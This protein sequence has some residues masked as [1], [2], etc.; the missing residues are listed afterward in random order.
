MR[1][2]R[3]GFLRLGVEVSAGVGLLSR[4]DLPE[5]Q[6]KERQPQIRLTTK[7]DRQEISLDGSW[8]FQPADA[9]QGVNP[10]ELTELNLNDQQWHHINVPDFW[11]PIDWWLYSPAGGASSEFVAE[12]QKRVAKYT[13]DIWKTLAGWY[14]HWIEIPGGLEGKRFVLRFTGVASVAEVWWNGHKV[15][16]H[17]GMFGPFE[18]DVTSYV[19]PG[20]RNLLSVFVAAQKFDLQ[21]ASEQVDLAVTVEVTRDM[22]SNLAHGG[23]DMEWVDR[24]GGIW[25]PV[26]LRLK[27]S[28]PS[29]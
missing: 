10:T 1:I 20:A 5:G 28:S 18:C 12:E 11:R 8:L 3:R 4:F 27:T 25:A 21:A 13:F 16:S 15:G 6:V 19:R 26:K 2:D 7:G 22:V 9:L 17:I 24:N 14:R 23:Y 29:Q